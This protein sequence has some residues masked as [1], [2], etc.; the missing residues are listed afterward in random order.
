MIPKRL[1][2][3]L[4]SVYGT[5]GCIRVEQW[6]QSDPVVYSLWHL[7]T[8]FSPV[9]GCWCPLSL[10]IGVDSGCVHG[11]QSDPAVHL[12]P[13]GRSEE[14]PAS[15]GTPTDTPPGN[16]PPPCSPGKHTHLSLCQLCF[17]WSVVITCVCIQVADAILGNQMFTHYDR[18]HIAQ[19]CEKA[20]LLQRA[21]E[22]Y[23]DLFDIKRTLVHT[24][25]L[26][27]EVCTCRCVL[28]VSPVWGVL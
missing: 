28:N 13:I 17:S 20:G 23:T 12:I 5:R 15:R 4:H 19:L 7:I 27:P 16:E 1:F 9:V 10:L 11:G 24:H 6:E 25:L 2:W 22:H 3:D 18:A 26:N 8:S 14:Q 21:L